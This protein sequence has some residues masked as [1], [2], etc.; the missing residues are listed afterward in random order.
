MGFTQFEPR[1]PSVR[2]ALCASLGVGGD[3]DKRNG[4]ALN[5]L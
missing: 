2:C 3:R 4:L 1:G 5:P